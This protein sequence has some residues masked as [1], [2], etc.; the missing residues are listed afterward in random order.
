MVVVAVGV[1]GGH[2]RYRED[3]HQPRGDADDREV[4]TTSRRA[5]RAGAFPRAPARADERDRCRDGSR[6][7]ERGGDEILGADRLHLGERTEQADRA[8]QCPDRNASAVE[9]DP[10]PHDE[11][12]GP[13]E[14]AGGPPD[15]RDGADREHP[16]EVGVTAVGS[17]GRRMHEPGADGGDGREEERGR[18]S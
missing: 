1:T 4:E 18:G 7:A 16:R 2:R 15:L 12:P 10:R 6:R 17:R 5:A 8:R 13:G 3:E 11:V 9:Q 14:R